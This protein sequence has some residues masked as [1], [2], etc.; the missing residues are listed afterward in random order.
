MRQKARRQDTRTGQTLWRKGHGT[1]TA[2]T[3]T[4][5]ISSPKGLKVHYYEPD[6]RSGKCLLDALYRQID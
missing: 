6:G 1:S 3:A 2:V 4:A 5:V